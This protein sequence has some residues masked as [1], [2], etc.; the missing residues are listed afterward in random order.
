MDSTWPLS[1]YRSRAVYRHLVHRGIPASKLSLEAFG[2]Y[3]PRYTNSTPEGRQKNRRVDLVLDKRNREW[4]K[5]VEALQEKEGPDTE[6]YYKGFK[7]D[8]TMPGSTV[9]GEE[10]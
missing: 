4:I 1:F 9:P 3:H 6:M 10:P 7:F 8:L 2:Q 5:K